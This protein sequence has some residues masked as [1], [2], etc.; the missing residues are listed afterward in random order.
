MAD[1]IRTKSTSR[2]S[3][4]AEPITLRETTTTRRLFR[5][6]VVDN[7][8][9]PAASVRGTLAHQRKGAKGSW[10]D[11]SAFPLS[12]LRDGEWVKL[13]LH[14]E[15]LLRLFEELQALYALSARHGVP[16]G[17]REFIEVG[18]NVKAI[19]DQPELAGRLLSDVELDLLGAFVRWLA[20]N[21]AEAVTRL[22]RDV[23]TEHLSAFDSLLAAARLRQFKDEFHTN[24]TNKSESF[25]SDLFK[26]SSW[27]IARLF[28]HPFVLIHDRAYVGGKFI[29]NKGGSVADFLYENRLTGNVLIVEIKTPTTPL[30]EGEDR[31]RVFPLSQAVTAAVAQVLTYRRTL[32]EQYRQ[33]RGDE[34]TWAAF[35]PKCLVLTGSIKQE[36]MN[37][38]MRQS[39]ELQRSQLRDVDVVTYDELSVQIDAVLELVSEPG[40]T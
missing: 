3:A 40:T 5:P 29:T 36:K 23:S 24:A 6:T 39:F 19:L 11:Y 32:M 12:A 21:P 14:A 10:E 38:H 1:R 8:K 17:E 13:D 25:W 4:D 27:V 34:E 9:N 26:R 7:Q 33:L 30:L 28:S 16:L 37:S 2:S 18:R 31:N 15:E 20:D 22:Q 35:S